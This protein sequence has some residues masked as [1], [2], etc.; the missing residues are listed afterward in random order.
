MNI[1]F[2][3]TAGKGPIIMDPIR[4]QAVSF[5]PNPSL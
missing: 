2:D 5:L 3:I 1:P 4:T